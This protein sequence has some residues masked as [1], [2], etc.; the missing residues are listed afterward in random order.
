MPRH[1]RLGLT[2]ALLS[3][4]GLA[5]LA[6]AYAPVAFTVGSGERAFDSAT[7]RGKFLAVHLLPRGPSAA[8]HLA[9]FTQAPPVLAGVRHIFIASG[10]DADVATLAAAAPSG[11]VVADPDGRVA[12]Q[13]HMAGALPGVAV[14]LLDPLGEELFRLVAKSDADHP[15][16][17]AFA[18]RLAATSPDKSVKE[19]NADHG[20]ALE[21]YDPVAYF[22]DLKATAGS[23]AITSTYRGITYRFAT[24]P[25]RQAFNDNPE[26]YLPAYGGWCATAMAKGEKVEVDPKSFK[27]T[28]GRLFLFY[29]GLFANAIDDWNKAE[30]KLTGD[31][32]NSWG[33]LVH[34]R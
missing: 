4:A 19:G 24:E 21:G 20:L 1:L 13:L 17:K 6:E 34:T 32:D 25:H 8:V 18:D 31:A 15:T 2:L 28:N 3:A 12:T 26:K 7:A 16:F 27:V 23:T 22:D 11:S 14:I 5:P 9:E 10:S 29:K 33:K 30:R